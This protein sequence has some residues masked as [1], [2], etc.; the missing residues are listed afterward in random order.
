VE[1]KFQGFFTL[2]RLKRQKERERE[3]K[4]EEGM[5]SNTYK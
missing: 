4:T 3:E 1:E 5:R 2:Y